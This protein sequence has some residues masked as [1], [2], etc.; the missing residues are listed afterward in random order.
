MSTVTTITWQTTVC[1]S[2]HGQQQPG[3][4]DPRSCCN[5]MTAWR[6]SSP[7]SEANGVHEVVAS[8]DQTSRHWIQ[9]EQRHEGLTAANRVG[10]QV[11][12]QALHNQHA[13]EQ[14]LWQV[15]VNM[16]QVFIATVIKGST[17]TKIQE[18]YVKTKVT[19]RPQKQDNLHVRFKCRVAPD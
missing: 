8:C 5:D 14:V 12:P 19:A 15:I 6:W 9:S 4:R 3:K 10:E 17:K 13:T 1:C 7:E 2:M 16:K 18:K 11:T